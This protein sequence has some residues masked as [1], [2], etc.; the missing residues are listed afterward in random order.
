MPVNAAS[1]TAAKPVARGVVPH[2][3]E[4]C[5]TFKSS[6]AA[7]L[8]VMMLLQQHPCFVERRS[9][10]SGHRRPCSSR[11][12][13][14]SRVGTLPSFLRAGRRLYRSWTV[15]QCWCT[16]STV[17]SFSFLISLF[18]MRIPHLYPI[19]VFYR[20]S[21]VCSL[22]SL[23]FFLVCTGPKAVSY[24]GLLFFLGYNQSFSCFQVSYCPAKRGNRAGSSRNEFNYSRIG[25]QAIFP[26]LDCR[27]C[28]NLDYLINFLLEKKVDQSPHFDQ[29]PVF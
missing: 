3:V 27:S 8:E 15:Y 12:W 22:F 10:A 26:L 1:I 25:T 21:K 5:C 19:L 16:T 20:K 23:L 2:R 29:L 24:G 4:C 18:V 6:V 11:V 7:R 17:D 28:D 9:R 14:A 13:S